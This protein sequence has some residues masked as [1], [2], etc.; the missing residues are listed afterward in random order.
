MI[1]HY[2]KIAVRNLA[3]QKALSFI[4]IAGLSIGGACR[5]NQGCVG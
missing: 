3:R 4:N 1:K 2:F 5:T